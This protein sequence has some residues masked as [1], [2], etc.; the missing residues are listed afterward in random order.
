MVE[1]HALS[2]IVKGGKGGEE[3][4]YFACAHY[5]NHLYML[6]AS[7]Q[8]IIYIIEELVYIILGS[9]Q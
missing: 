4:S 2:S 7:F 9:C 1:I 5:K 8:L 6:V 3:G